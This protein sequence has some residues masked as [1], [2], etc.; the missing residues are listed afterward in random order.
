MLAELL[1]NS[2]WVRILNIVQILVSLDGNS[3]DID[4]NDVLVLIL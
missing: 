3:V 2:L 1:T 4:G